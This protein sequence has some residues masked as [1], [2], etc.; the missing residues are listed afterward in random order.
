MARIEADKRKQ[1]G[2]QVT[3]PPAG[4]PRPKARTRFA[5]FCSA[6]EMRA[7][8]TLHEG[9]GRAPPPRRGDTPERVRQTDRR[10]RRPGQ[11]RGAGAQRAP[12]GS[13]DQ[14]RRGAEGA[15]RPSSRNRSRALE[16]RHVKLE[17][18]TSM[19]HAGL[20]HLLLTRRRRR[21]PQR[22]KLGGCPRRASTVAPRAQVNESRDQDRCFFRGAGLSRWEERPAGG[23]TA[24]T[25]GRPGNRLPPGA[26]TRLRVE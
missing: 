26:M 20:R 22:P 14:T 13:A 2:P 19:A 7:V 6:A 1:G 25:T 17:E 18:A 12:L 23:R 24:G 10:A 15:H 9:S 11:R 4:R 16:K 21:L 5:I 8:E 3:D